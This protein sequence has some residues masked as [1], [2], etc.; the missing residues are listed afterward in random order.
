MLDEPAAA[1]SDP[2]VVELQLR[3]VTKR[4]AVRA[5]RVKRVPRDGSIATI[6]KWIRDISDLHRTKPPPSVQYS[7]PMPDID[8]LMEVS[9]A[10]L[11]VL[12]KNKNKNNKNNK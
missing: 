9:R 10:S 6:D 12:H 7:K 2:S 11:S 8:N 3:V 4:S 5:G 1:Q